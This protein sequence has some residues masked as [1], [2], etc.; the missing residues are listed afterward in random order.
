M[1]LVIKIFLNPS[2][3]PPQ[4]LVINILL[5]MAMYLIVLIFNYAI[6]KFIQHILHVCFLF[7]YFFWWSVSSDILSIFNQ[8]IRFVLNFKIFFLY[9]S[10]KI[11]YLIYF[12]QI[13]S[14]VCG[15]SSYFWYCLRAD[16]FILIKIMYF[17]IFCFCAGFKMSLPNPKACR[18][19]ILRVI[20][21]CF[22]F[23]I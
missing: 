21:Y 9:I 20:F 1:Y 12:L 3:Q 16:I 18:C 5:S 17:I 23:Y 19:Y 8:A 22:S 13:Y 2:F 4:L 14:Q 15:L 7:V 6:T 10:D 11:I